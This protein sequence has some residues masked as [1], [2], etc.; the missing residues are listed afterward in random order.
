VERNQAGN[1][2]V[3]RPITGAIVCRQPFGGWKASS[4]GPGAKAGGPN[5]VLQL[6]RW[7]QLKLPDG[8]PDPLAEPVAEL[9]ARCLGEPS[10]G[11]TRALLT[12]SAASYAEAW[13]AHFGCEHDPSSIR[14]ERNAFRYR[15]CRRVIVRG[16]PGAQLCQVLLAAS[17]VATPLTLSLPPDARAWPW[18]AD[19][20]GVELAVEGEAGFAARLARPGDAERVRIWEPISAAARTAANDAG[21]SVIDAPP[22]ASGRLELRWYLREQTVSRVLH[23]YGNVA[24]P[25]AA[26]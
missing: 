15:P 4:V 2:Y 9:L 22:L 3:N 12:A 16:R 26:E 10:D 11:D 24:D 7:S 19:L 18:L 1:L 8:P 23:R 13:R 21:V 25:A 20:E 14:G 17:V 6:A 5:Y